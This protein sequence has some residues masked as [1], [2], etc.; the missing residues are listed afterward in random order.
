MT[1]RFPGP[2]RIAE[3]PNGFAVYDATGRQLGFFYGRAD[4]NMAGHADFLTIGDARQIAVDFARLPE[5]LNQTS[6]RSEVATSPEDDRL[7]KLETNRSPQAGP[8]TSRLL[9]PAQLSVI[10]VGGSPLAK[11]PTTIRRSIPFKP[12]GRRSTRM[13]RRPPLS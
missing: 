11:A 9:R 4:P 5:L 8:E 10:T 2:W 12:D 1:S 13:L 6:G 3:F 7:A